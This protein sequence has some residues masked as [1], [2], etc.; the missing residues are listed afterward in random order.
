M[1]SGGARRGGGRGRGWGGGE[2]ELE[3]F[4]VVPSV[5]EGGGGTAGGGGE[6][7][8]GGV[9]GAAGA[10]GVEEAREVNAETVGE[11]H[12]GGG[13]TAGA[14]EGAVG[15]AGL[16]G[17]LVGVAVSPRGAKGAGDEKGV[18][19][20]CGGT[21]DGSAA[22]DGAEGGDVDFE[23]G[24]FR[25]VAADDGQAKLAC[26]GFEG[27]VELTDRVGREFGGRH[28]IGE[29]PRHIAAH[30]RDVGDGSRNG[31]ASNEAKR[32]GVEEVVIPND[33]VSGSEQVAFRAGEAQNRAVVAGADGYVRTL[34]EA[35]KE[36][37]EEGDFADGG[38]REGHGA[39]EE[40]GR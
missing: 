24:A 25:E 7:D 27:A 1:G 35:W 13:E 21:Q 6:G 10:G 33:G 18:A 3:V 4:A 29:N 15:E 12:Y 11:I 26:C 38:E 19:G 5:G 2:E 30:G 23:V 34:E 22:G 37:T 9:E 40:D 8:G 16:E 20:V 28:D 36:R 32:R 31:L 14:E 39:G 17:V